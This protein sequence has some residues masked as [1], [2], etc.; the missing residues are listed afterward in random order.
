MSQGIFTSKTDEWGTPQDFFDE[1]D[2]EF[3]FT[4]DPCGRHDRRLKEGLLTLDIR[5][6]EDGLKHDW[7][8]E[9]VFVNPPYSQKNVESWCKK[10]FEEKDRAYLI[11][12]LLPV[13]KTS[14]KYFHKYI[15]PYAE[16]RLIEGRLKFYPLEG[17]TQSS[18]PM[19]S[20][21][22]VLRRR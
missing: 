9:R 14:T 7:I 5:K 11:V 15:Y 22:C 6:G 20:M 3:K 21:L 8:G 1:L 17:Q 19:G 4:L 2:K 13:A 18:N 12:M 16:I 10:A